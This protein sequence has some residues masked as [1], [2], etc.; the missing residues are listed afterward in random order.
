MVRGP[1]SPGGDAGTWAI[2]SE[3]KTFL[4]LGKGDS[5][6]TAE[7]REEQ[8]GVKQKKKK[9]GAKNKGENRAR[10][11]LSRQIEDLLGGTACSKRA[12][13]GPF[14]RHAIWRAPK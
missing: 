10:L 7:C 8:I 14:E 6:R 11:N 1:A 5:L 3:H 13:A 2:G 4:T 9:I 12:Y